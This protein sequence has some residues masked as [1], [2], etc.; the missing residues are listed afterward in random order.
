MSRQAAQPRPGRAGVPKAAEAENDIR[1]AAERLGLPADDSDDVDK[2]CD[3]L[4]GVINDD[5][6]YRRFMGQLRE[7]RRY[8]GFAQRPMN[9]FLFYLGRFS[10]GPT[11][12]QMRTWIAHSFRCTMGGAERLRRTALVRRNFAADFHA[13][14]FPGIPRSPMDGAVDEETL[15][16]PDGSASTGGDTEDDRS[17]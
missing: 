12:P 13:D 7:C 2:I 11:D 17:E 4:A 9:S 16:V 1:A 14:E 5:P 8:A 10:A 15:A 3:F 6:A